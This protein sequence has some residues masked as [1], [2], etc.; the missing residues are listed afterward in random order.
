MSQCLAEKRVKTSTIRS[1][2]P[3]C[4]RLGFD[5]VHQTF[6]LTAEL[7]EDWPPYEADSETWRLHA[8]CVHI[9]FT[10]DCSLRNRNAGAVPTMRTSSSQEQDT[11]I[12]DSPE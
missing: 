8:I 12:L 4:F 2:Q 3:E 10:L 7:I 1:S 11:K 6:F 5:D 9:D